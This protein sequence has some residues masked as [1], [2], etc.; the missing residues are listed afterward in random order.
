MAYSQGLKYGFVSTTEIHDL[1]SETV[2]ENRP[3]KNLNVNSKISTETKTENYRK[4]RLGLEPNTANR[5][6]SYRNKM[7]AVGRF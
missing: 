5:I 4:T 7:S 6:R 2:R 1:I 3:P